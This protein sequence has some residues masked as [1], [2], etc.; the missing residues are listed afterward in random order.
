MNY[1]I[2]IDLGGTKTEVIVIHKEEIKLRERIP[3]RKES[4]DSILETIEEVLNIAKKE[5]PSNAKITI[6]MGIPGILDPITE[7]V[8]NA[9]TTI[10]IGRNLKKDLEEKIQH[11]VHI[12]NDANCFALAEAKMGAARD[13]QTVFGIIMGTGCGGGLILDKKIYKGRHGIAGEWGHF[14]IDPKGF[15]CWCGNHGCIELYLS[16]S[17]IENQYYQITKTKAKVPEILNL[18]HKGD[19]IAKEIFEQFLE[20]FGKAVGGL[21]S[22]LDPD[23][24][25]LG[26][27]LSNIEELYTVG[28]EKVK[29][30][31]FHHNITTPLLKNQ[32]GDS[33]GVIGAAWLGI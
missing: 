20:N 27:G 4:Y 3:T 21:I 7:K 32:L 19:S 31:A 6:G 8:I 17:G 28:Y 2:G 30:Y 5:I 14:S 9:N 33:S 11:E 22:I 26:G 12:E 1:Q 13:Y 25:V 23:A 18:V 29:K 15:K 10:L 16:G 24:I